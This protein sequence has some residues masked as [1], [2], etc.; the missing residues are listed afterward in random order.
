MVETLR[1]VAA[2][3]V[4]LHHWTI[5]VKGF[6]TDPF[7]FA[8]CEKMNIGVYIF[9][10]ISG[11]IMP[12]AL[13]RGGYERTQFPKFVLKRIL[14]LDPPFIVSILW[15]LGIAYLA[16]LHPRYTGVPF[17]LD[18]SNLALHLLYLVPFFGE[19]WVQG[20]IYW[21]LGIE[22]QYY[23]LLGLV[24]PLLVA[25][26]AWLAW[27][28]LAGFTALCVFDEGYRFLFVLPYTPFFAAGMV[29]FLFRVGRVPQAAYLAVLALL[30][31]LL[32]WRF[33]VH[34]AAGCF[35]AS[36]LIAYWRRPTAPLLFFG[37]ISYSLYLFHFPVA[38][39]AVNF[40][41]R[42]DW[43]VRWNWL[44]VLLGCALCIGLAWVMYWVVERPS[45][46]LAQSIRYGSALPVVPAL[47]SPTP[48]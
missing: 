19:T 7:M 9:F 27:G 1:G 36:L 13:Y 29:T 2:L 41:M 39:K 12:Y 42:Y 31:A 43:A 33:E 4:L 38:L 44:I 20:G 15:C 37:T 48:S 25:R 6:V 24:F 17:V 5:C 32:L 34:Q 16:T 23:L 14:R 30:T 11:F 10:T 3:A 45:K 46:R 40:L 8:L 47:P 35:S 21:T 28:T 22:F 18:W 26:R